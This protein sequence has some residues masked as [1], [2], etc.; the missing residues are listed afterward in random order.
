MAL[1]HSSVTTATS[2]SSGATLDVTGI[3]ASVGDMLVLACEAD[4]AGT[5]GV[6]STSATI[7]DAAG[8]TWTRRSVTTNSP[9]GSANDGTTLSIWTCLVTFALSSAT[10]TINFSP[11]TTS[12][13]AL[14]KKYVPGAGE[15]VNF[16]AVG[17]GVTGVLTGTWAAPTVSVAQDQTIV[18]FVGSESRNAATADS[19]TTDGSWSAD[20]SA[21]ADTG[22]AGTSQTIAAQSKTVTGT[23]NQT[24]DR[25]SGNARE[26]AANYIIIAAGTAVVAATLGALTLSSTGALAIAGTLSST[27]DSLSLSATGTPGAIPTPPSSLAGTI[28]L[29]G[30]PGPAGSIDVPTLT[31]FPID[32]GAGVIDLHAARGLAI[33]LRATLV[34]PDALVTI[35]GPP[36]PAGFLD[37]PTAFEVDFLGATQTIYPAAS[38]GRSSLPDDTPGDTYVP[39]KLMPINFGTKLFD[40][41]EP[42]PRGSGGFGAIVLPDPDGELDDLIDLAW[43]GA[44]L[45]ILRGLPLARY[46]SYEVVGRMSTAGL[47]YDQRKKEIRLRD[48][49]WQLQQAELHGLRYGGTGGADGDAAIA[50]AMKPYGVGT[51]ENAEPVAINATLLLYALSCSS[52]VGVDEVRDGGVALDFDADYTSYATLAAATVPAGHYSTCIAE[53]FLRLGSTPVYGITVDFQGDADTIGGLGAPT[54]MGTIARRIATGRGSLMLSTSQL[55]SVSFASFESERTAAVGFY[56][57]EP[58]SK[59]EALDEVLAGTLGWWTVR[60]NGK[61]A[62]GYMREPTDAPALT[63]DYPEDFAGEPKHL[64]SYQAPRRATYVTWQRNYTIQDASR[65]AGSVDQAD[66][67]IWAQGGRLASSVSGN[68]ASI[69]PTSATVAVPG[70]Y[71]D[72]S[73]AL[74]EASREQLLMSVR[75]ERWSVP[76]PCDPFSDLLGRVVQVNGF[77]R[78]GWGASRRF[79]CVGMSF[80]SSR[81][82]VLDL[83]G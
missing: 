29:T 26:W 48:L 77:S 21:I 59:A 32:A 73:A 2:T 67:V 65:L 78:Y 56:W 47:F 12:K 58:I 82:T 80:A 72:E 40:G 3:T 74:A 63:I 24:Y 7:T 49:G 14:L 30:Y 61:L 45:D 6:S 60:L 22:S 38:L 20:Q 57:R 16:I 33:L 11:N 4:N 8:N 17:A 25:T 18:G 35:Q 75:R 46:D 64:G 68:T 52:I 19:D 31:Q 41:I 81:A 13:A 15:V 70:A 71:R 43:D 9:G 42:S 55:D 79:I 69:W 27:L 5:A 83:W 51:V 62:I 10:I 36:Y 66:R 34:D 53:G 76:V 50:G 39:G 23:G 1:T 37:I 28:Y 44:A 54:T